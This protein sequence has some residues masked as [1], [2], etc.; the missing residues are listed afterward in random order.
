MPTGYTCDVQNG[1]ITEFKDFALKCARAFGANIMMRDDPMDAPIKEYEPSSYHKEALEK[2]EKR[3]PEVQE[4]SPQECEE[5]AEKE[6]TEAK[7]RNEKYISEANEQRERYEQMLEKVRS[8]IPPTSEHQGLK[9]FMI[10]Q[11]TDSIEWDCSTEYYTNPERKTGEQWRKDQIDSLKHDIEYHS[12]H[13][14]EEVDRTNSR[15]EWNRQL[16]DSLDGSKTA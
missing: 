9:E 13:H 7:E 1:K 6:Y 4:M 2:A 16:F 11:L 3:L 8:W 12:K 10:K 5:Q 14:A 15:N